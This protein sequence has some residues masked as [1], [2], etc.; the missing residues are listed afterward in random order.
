MEKGVVGGA[1]LIGR[2]T[3]RS[4]SKK[5]GLEKIVVAVWGCGGGL[6]LTLWRSCS[7]DGFVMD[8]ESRPGPDL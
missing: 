3:C 5:S 6:V 7:H 8:E 1:S 2:E 4:A